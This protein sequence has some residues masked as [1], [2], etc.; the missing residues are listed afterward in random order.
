MFSN[1]GEFSTL[2]MLNTINIYF[3][4]ISSVFLLCFMVGYKTNKI[5][6][7]SFNTLIFKNVTLIIFSLSFI[8]FLF[9]FYCLFQFKNMLLVFNLV[10]N[11]YSFNYLTPLILDTPSIIIIY[12]CYLIGFI[13][14]ITLGDRFWAYNYTLSILFIYFIIIINLLCQSQSLFELF[15]YYELLLLP[16]VLF[17]YKTGYTKK[18]HQANIYFF[19]WT[20]LGSLLVL[21]GILYI[22]YICGATSFISLKGFKFT[23]TELY[24]IYLFFFFG[25]GVKVPLWPL[26][27]WLI[28][29]HVEAPSGFSIFLSGFLVKSA[30]YCF[31]KII[32]LLNINF[33]YVLPVILCLLGMLDASLKMWT[34]VD[35][36]KIIAYAT[37][38]EMNAI[39]LL[40]NV[41]DSWAVNAGL[42]F[43]LA[44][45][46]LSALM[47]YLVECIYKRYDSR[48]LLKIYGVSQL[49]PNLSIAI[50]AMLI[51][52]FGLPGTLKFYVEI[53][54]VLLLA[55]NDLITTFFILL[56]FIFINAIGFGRCWF[57][58]LYGH[59]GN[60]ITHSKPKLDLSQEEFSIITFLVIFSITPCFFIFLL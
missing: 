17:V 58:V 6:L 48:S 50:W 36:K 60:D 43:L 26:H 4:V 30:V 1:I 2:L 12:L 20:Q 39:Y 21:F 49:Y 56:I 40:F 32:I 34:Q 7:G 5:S 14:I 46:I 54:L 57:S 24:I 19:I 53:Q 23:S 42:I 44:H 45:G 31:Y 9:Y 18:S 51:L 3:L 16:S 13:S 59:P 28:K 52:F 25:F 47:F 55:N 22:S 11:D 29:V 33:F 41:G 37:V 15:I 27:F 10:H 38:Q 35:I 8:I